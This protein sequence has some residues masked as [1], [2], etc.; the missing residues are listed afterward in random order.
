MTG[1]DTSGWY[2]PGVLLDILHCTGQPFSS[3]TKNVPA[4]VDFYEEVVDVKGPWRQI[5]AGGADASAWG[6]W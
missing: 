5:Y 1:I 3:S 4:L 6:G 2:S